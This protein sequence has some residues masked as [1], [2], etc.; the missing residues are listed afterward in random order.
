MYLF[1]TMFDKQYS[2]FKITI[3]VPYTSQSVRLVP[4]MSVEISTP[5]PTQNPIMMY[6][7]L[8]NNV[9]ITKYGIDVK[10]LDRINTLFMKSEPLG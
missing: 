6:K 10:R 1:N 5:L 7:D 2:L 4:G 8:I 3:V 9:F